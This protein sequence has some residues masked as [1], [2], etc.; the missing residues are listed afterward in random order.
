MY[1]IQGEADSADSSER[2]TQELPPRSWP[3][4]ATQVL[5]QK[6]LNSPDI[7]QMFVTV[8]VYIYVFIMTFCS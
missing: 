8:Y 1:D 6:Q 3:R 4:A 2:A 7:L 5:E